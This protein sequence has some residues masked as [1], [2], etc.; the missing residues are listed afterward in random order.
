MAVRELLLEKGIF[1]PDEFRS[2]L[3]Q[4]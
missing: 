2:K 3:E 4:L 1:S